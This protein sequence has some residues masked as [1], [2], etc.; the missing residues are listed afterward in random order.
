VAVERG[1]LAAGKK[2]AGHGMEG[3]LKW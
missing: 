1:Q 2:L 3:W